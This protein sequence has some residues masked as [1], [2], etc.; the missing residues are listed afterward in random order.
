MLWHHSLGGFCWSQVLALRALQPLLLVSADMSSKH[1]ALLSSLLGSSSTPAALQLQAVA[2][3]GAVVACRPAQHSHLVRQLEQLILYHPADSAAIC[4][5][6]AGAEGVQASAP[7]IC[8]LLAHG[9]N[10]TMAAVAC[11]AAGVYC[12]LLLQQK[13]LLAGNSWAVIA[14]GLLADGQSQVCLVCD[15]LPGFT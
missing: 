15:H 9:G 4:P 8:R 2:T 5:T 12:Q 6:T 14:N 3:T 11:A 7:S 1:Q 10:A 13:L